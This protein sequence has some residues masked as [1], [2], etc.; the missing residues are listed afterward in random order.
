MRQIERFLDKDWI[1]MRFQFDVDSQPVMQLMRAYQNV[2]MF[3]AD[4]CLVRMA[5]LNE[6]ARVSTLYKGFRT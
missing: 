5:E 3:F 4:A 2:P 6:K 1:Q